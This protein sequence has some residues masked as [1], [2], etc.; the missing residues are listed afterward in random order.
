[1]WGLHWRARSPLKGIASFG[2]L[3]YQFNHQITQIPIYRWKVLAPLDIAHTYLGRDRYSWS[4]ASYRITENVLVK[5]S[6]LAVFSRFSRRDGAN[7]VCNALE[8]RKSARQTITFNG[9]E[10]KKQSFAHDESY[11]TD[12]Y[13]GGWTSRYLVFLYLH[14]FLPLPFPAPAFLLA[15]APAFPF[16]SGFFLATALGFGTTLKKLLGVKGRQG[17]GRHFIA[18][19]TGEGESQKHI[20]Y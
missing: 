15:P 4:S 12:R 7:E 2:G 19:L 18:T 8:T 5:I 6:S 14:R 10:N 16:G 1:M 20:L 11:Y 13:R 17:V 9:K 3:S